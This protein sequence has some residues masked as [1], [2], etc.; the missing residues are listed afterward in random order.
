MVRKIWVHQCIPGD[1]LLQVGYINLNLLQKLG[2]RILSP[3]DLH[4]F[5]SN[6]Y[7]LIDKYF[8]TI[9]KKKLA[10]R[11]SQSKMGKTKKKSYTYISQIATIYSIR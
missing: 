4:K 6:R 7:F 1:Y 3:H 10:L 11:P 9:Y 5:S 2:I 8:K